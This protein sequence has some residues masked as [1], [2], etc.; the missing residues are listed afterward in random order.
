MLTED[1]ETQTREELFIELYEEVFPKVAVFIKKMGGDLD[2]TKDVFQDALII[3]YEKTKSTDYVIEV[4]ERA[5][6]TGICKYLW[7]QKQRQGSKYQRLDDAING[8]WIQQEEVRVSPAILNFIERAGKKCLD[9]LQ[10][11][12]YERRSMTEISEQFKFSNE[13]SATAQKYKCL[14]K[15][16]A[17]IKNKSMQKEDFYE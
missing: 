10:S 16:R 1:C 2:D 15:V 7:F 8:G 5:Y 11:F 12:Y 14:E 17:I 4:N 3:Y 9:L 13:R 6:L